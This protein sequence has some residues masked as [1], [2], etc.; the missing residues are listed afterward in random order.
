MNTRIWAPLGPSEI[1][2]TCF[3]FCLLDTFG[4]LGLDTPKSQGL[5]ISKPLIERKEQ[6]LLIEIKETLDRFLEG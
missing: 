1:V 2:G 3:V 6:L 4:P 5:K